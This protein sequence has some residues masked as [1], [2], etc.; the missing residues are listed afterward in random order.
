VRNAA[1]APAVDDGIVD[2]LQGGEAVADL[3][4]TRPGHSAVGAQPWLCC[5]D[6]RAVVGWGYSGHGPAAG[7]ESF[8]AEQP[9][10]PFAADPD[11]VLATK[12]GAVLAVAL[13]GY[14]KASRTWRINPNRLA[15]L[16]EV[17]RPGRRP[18]PAE[19]RRA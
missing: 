2:R 10:D 5:G 6:D 3:G 15:S 4:H 8:L 12:S 17:T 14:G 1:A 16:I 9:Q 19:A 11:A 7:Q 13:P 18:E